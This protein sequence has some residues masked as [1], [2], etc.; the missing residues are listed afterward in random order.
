MKQ[1]K[2]RVL[3]SY[4]SSHPMRHAPCAML[5]LRR[6]ATCKTYLE[7]ED[8]VA[9]TGIQPGCVHQ[10]LAQNSQIPADAWIC[11]HTLSA[12]V[13][14]WQFASDK[15]AHGLKLHQLIVKSHIPQ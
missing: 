5:P 6:T 12:R 7:D 2:S 3:S 9:Q 15:T 10:F 4:S 11:K 8:P 1:G 14:F 13:W